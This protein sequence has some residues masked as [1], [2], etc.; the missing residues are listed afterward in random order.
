MKDT[1]IPTGPGETRERAADAAAHH[2]RA[3]VAAIDGA[4]G[5]GYAREN[6]ALVASLVQAAAIESAVETGREAH[7]QTLDL[8]QR[9]SR[10]TN[11]TIL[12]L[13]PRLF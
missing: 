1:D 8:V 9:L 10:E 3:A 13:K 4:F 12:R 7:H 6:P 11:E 5:Q 2:L